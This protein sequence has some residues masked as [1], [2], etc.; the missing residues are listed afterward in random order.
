MR[1]AVRASEKQKQEFLSSTMPAGIK[2]SWIDG[3]W[4]EADAYFDLLFD[5]NNLPNNIFIKDK[6]VFVN[7]VTIT[8]EVLTHKLCAYQCVAG[9]C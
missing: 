8:G 6:I 9:I 5:E 7:A 1:I 2:L 4:T 3:E